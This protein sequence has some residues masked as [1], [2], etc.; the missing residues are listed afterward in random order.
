[1]LWIIKATDYTDDT[2]Y[3]FNS[4]L[5]V[6]LFWKI[7]YMDY[8]TSIPFLHLGHDPKLCWNRQAGQPALHPTQIGSRLEL[9][10]G[11]GTLASLPQGRCQSPLWGC[12]YICLVYSRRKPKHS[13]WPKLGPRRLGIWMRP[14]VCGQNSTPLLRPP[15]SPEYP[16]PTPFPPAFPLPS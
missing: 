10:R 12:S 16:P 6:F 5:H 1:M 4:W 3:R 11:K 2:S 13:M 9:P 7:K 15:C 14:F 8:Y